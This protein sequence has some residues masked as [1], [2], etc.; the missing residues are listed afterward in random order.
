[1]ET[2]KCTA[3]SYP[4]HSKLSY[5]YSVFDFAY[6]CL[7][8][9][10]KLQGLLKLFDEVQPCCGNSDEKFLSLSNIHKGVMLDK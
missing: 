7:T 3:E 2:D 10:D 5:N 4:S 6:V 9:V 1:M 8:I